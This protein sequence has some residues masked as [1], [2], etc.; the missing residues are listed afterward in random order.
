VLDR[1]SK[2]QHAVLQGRRACCVA[3]VLLVNVHRERDRPLQHL[4]NEPMAVRG[5]QCA[6]VARS[7]LEKPNTLEKKMM[8]K[9]VPAF[10]ATA[11]SALL[12]SSSAFAFCVAEKEF[13][14]DD[15][16]DDFGLAGRDS[17]E[18]RDGDLGG[19]VSVKRIDPNNYTYLIG[20]EGPTS[21]VG[22]VL[23]DVTGSVV[24][25]FRS[26]GTAD[27]RPDD[28]Q[29]LFDFG[30]C[31]QATE[32]HGAPFISGFHCINTN[33]EVAFIRVFVE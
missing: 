1:A 22:G 7:R 6:A 2:A 4:V 28:E 24:S 31:N 14:P 26:D 5:Y 33:A 17:I 11:L 25:G 18:C 16:T 9:P 29:Q 19:V 3:T 10:I 15:T 20:T 30:P 27:G 21:Q 32:A 12:A 8:K 23:L 13:T